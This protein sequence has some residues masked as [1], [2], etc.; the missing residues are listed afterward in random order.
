MLY[1]VERVVMNKI[2]TLLIMSLTISLLVLWNNRVKKE[3]EPFCVTYH[4]SVHT[5]SSRKILVTYTDTQGLVQDLFVGK[6]WEKKV[7]LSPYEIASLRIDEIF[8]GENNYNC[9]YEEEIHDPIAREFTIKP[10]S[11][12]IEHNKKTVLSAGDKKLQ[13][14]LLASEVNQ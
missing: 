3:K 4:V 8:D 6:R 5:P 1:F 2:Y 7:C 12:W 9:S 11:I 10:L 14:S 13:I